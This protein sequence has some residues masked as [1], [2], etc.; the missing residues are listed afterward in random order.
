MANKKKVSVIMPLYNAEKYVYK[1]IQCILNQTYKDYELILINDYS[2][3]GTMDI[4]NR[5]QDSRIKIIHNE[6]NRGIAFSRNVGLENAKGKYIALMDDDDLAP[7]DRLEKQVE[8]LDENRNIDAIGGRY[9]LIDESDCV[10]Q[11]APEALENPKYVKASLMFLD[12]LG[13]GSMM[14]R[15]KVVLDNNIRFQ[16]DCLGMEDY[17]FWVEFSKHGVISN[18]KDVLLYWRC[19]KGNETTKMLEQKRMARADKFFEIQKYAMESCGIKLSNNNLMLFKQ[20][21]PEGKWT[22]KA[23]KSELR[24]LYNVMKDIIRQAE[25]KQLDNVE[26]IRIICRKQFSKRVEFSEIW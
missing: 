11:M 12:P 6:C 23:S 15:K 9:C 17:L 25:Q 10:Y 18:L 16:D 19:V 8:F 4:V 14:F 21:F 20:M 1:T 5:I 24:E 26:E 13:N 2:T 3:D 7:I 22:N